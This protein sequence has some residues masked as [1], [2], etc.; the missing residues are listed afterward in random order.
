MK[1]YLEIARRR[2]PDHAIGGN[3]RF[4]VDTPGWKNAKILLFATREEAL[5]TI[6]DPRQCV[7]IDLDITG[8]SILEKIP[9]R[10]DYE[11][12]LKERREQ[13]G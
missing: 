13:R 1:N 7:I 11:D 2:W 4:A 12:R 6:I 5:R 10:Y 3:G 9:D 8:E